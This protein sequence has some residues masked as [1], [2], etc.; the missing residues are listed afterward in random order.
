M[1]TNNNEISQNI[2]NQPKKS[3]VLLYI[4]I[5]IAL[6]VLA[7]GG[8]YLYK[9]FGKKFSSGSSNTT[10]NQTTVSAT[11]T[12][13]S[14]EKATTQEIAKEIKSINVAELKQAVKEL[15][16]TLSSFNR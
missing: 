1:E 11:P 7:F 3:K 6:I 9:S 8:Y 10:S 5:Y 12:A 14:T 15:K 13:I 16:E 2:V 4:I